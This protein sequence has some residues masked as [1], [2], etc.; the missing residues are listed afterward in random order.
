MNQNWDF[1]INRV[2]FEKKLT[3]RGQCLF[4]KLIF[5]RFDVKGNPSP[6]RIWARPCT[7]ELDIILRHEFTLEIFANHPLVQD[8]LYM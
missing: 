3:L 5:Y 1:L 7:Q 2:G 8:E 4:K 6:Q